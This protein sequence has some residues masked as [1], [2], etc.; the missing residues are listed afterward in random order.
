MENY[1]VI[2][3]KHKGQEKMPFGETI[4]DVEGLE[5][6]AQVNDVFAKDNAFKL[7]LIMKQCR[8][9]SR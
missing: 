5:Q 9:K 1:D 4:I 2:S 8:Y 3:R 6:D 7:L